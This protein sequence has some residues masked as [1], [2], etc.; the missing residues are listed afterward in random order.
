MNSVPKTLFTGSYLQS[1]EKLMQQ[2]PR[3]FCEQDDDYNLQNY[4]KSE[5]KQKDLT[6]SDATN[7]NENK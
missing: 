6:A 3:H 7:S 5:S 2:V 1:Y 4:E